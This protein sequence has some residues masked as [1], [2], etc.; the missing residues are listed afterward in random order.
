MCIVQYEFEEENGA[1]GYEQMFMFSSG[2][3]H[4]SK[5]QQYNFTF[6]NLVLHIGGGGWGRGGRG[7]GEHTQDYKAIS[8]SKADFTLFIKTNLFGFL[9]LSGESFQICTQ[10][11]VNVLISYLFKIPEDT[12]WAVRR[13]KRSKIVVYRRNK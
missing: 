4:Q 12:A 10:R 2:S 1:A 6:N 5:S 11:A 7:R 9:F 3:P 8:S 13:F